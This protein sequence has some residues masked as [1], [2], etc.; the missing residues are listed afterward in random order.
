MI[1]IISDNSDKI[2]H[3]TVITNNK[4]HYNSNNKNDSSNDNHNTSYCNDSINLQQ[5]QTQ[6]KFSTPTTIT[7]IIH[8]KTLTK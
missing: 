5:Q 1:I 6:Q 2:T 3:A 4:S 8:V 7:K